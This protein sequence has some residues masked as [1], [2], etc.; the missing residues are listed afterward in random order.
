VAAKHSDP[1]S[2]ELEAVDSALRALSA[3]QHG[4]IDRRQVTDLGIASPSFNHRVSTGEW[5]RMGR[6]VLVNAAAPDSTHRQVM[7]S[8]LDA[9]EG[10]VLS[11]A[12]AASLWGLPGFTLLPA[13]VT[14]VRRGRPVDRPIGIVHRMRALRPHH[15][16][17]L[18]SIPVVRPEL[19]MLQL[20]G[21]VHPERLG[22]LLDRAWSMR[23]LSGRSTRMVL[24]EVAASGVRGVTSLRAALDERGDDYEPPASNLEGRFHQLIT[25][26]GLPA[27]RRQIDLGGDRWNGRVDFVATDRALVIEVDSERYHTA[28]SDAEADLLRETKLRDSGYTVGRV[29]DFQLFHRPAEVIELVRHLRHVATKHPR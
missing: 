15:T 28:L 25:R 27:M 2:V 22:V 19:L 4:A 26:A 21:I 5:Q 17:E 29:T 23:L 9:G 8:V 24:D 16:T 7:A 13:H 20:A 11:H 14:T 10:A 1:S 3:G 12:S 18:D 6:R